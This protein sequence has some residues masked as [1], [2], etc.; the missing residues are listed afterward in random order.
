MT[1]AVPVLADME[2]YA[3]LASAVAALRPAVESGTD[4]DLLTPRPADG[5]EVTSV[6]AV[7]LL[8][9]ADAAIRDEGLLTRPGLRYR[10]L[11]RRHGHRLLVIDFTGLQPFGHPFHD[12]IFAML[13][14]LGRVGGRLAICGAGAWYTDRLPMFSRFLQV[15]VGERPGASGDSVPDAEPDVTCDRGPQPS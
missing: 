5:P 3:D 6:G 9:P 15:V 14:E 12:D 2:L 1:N 7:T 8:R 13:R 10:D 11:V 4:V